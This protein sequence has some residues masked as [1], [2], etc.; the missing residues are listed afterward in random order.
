MYYVCGISDKGTVRDH[1]EDAFLIDGVVLSKAQLETDIRP[2]FIAAV[3]DGVGGEASGEVASR[4]ALE[5]LSSVKYGSKVNMQSKING[6]HGKLVRYGSAHRGCTNM[7]TTLCAIAVD[8]QENA[9]VINV[10]DSR[11]YRYRNGKIRQIS[12]DKSLVQLLY[13]QGK[14]SREEQRTHEHKNVIFPVLGNVNSSP[15]PEIK[16]ITGGIRGGD[17]III[18]TDGISDYITQGQFEEALALPMSLP[19][20]LQRLTEIA[21]ENGST[22][23]MTAIGVS[24]CGVHTQIKHSSSKRKQ[25]R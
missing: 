18:C 15:E 23:N 7:Q 1:N 13:E 11:M 3:A 21:V 8:E 14:I 25:V 6:I 5:L 20:R 9:S 16:P 12:T 2:P 4:L 17:V 19:K 22:D 24:C 10:G